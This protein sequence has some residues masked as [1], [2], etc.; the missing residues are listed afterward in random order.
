[1]SLV[2]VQW[3]EYHTYSEFAAGLLAL[4]SSPIVWL[5]AVGYS[6]EG[7]PIWAIKI[8]DYPNIKERHE[9]DVLFVGL[10]HAR[11]W[12]SA[13]VPYYFAW[14][15]VELYDSD[16]VVKRFVDNCEIWIVPVV[17]PDGLEFCRA[18]FE[19]PE[20]PGENSRYWR[21]NRVNNSDG[22]FGVDLNRNYGTSNWGQDVEEGIADGSPNPID[23]TYWGPSAFSEP[24]TVA[25]RDLIL[26]VENDFQAVVSYH[27][28]WQMI[29]YPWGYTPDPP[30][31]AASM[32][33]LSQGMAEAIHA[34]HGEEY[35]VVQGGATYL[36]VGDMGDWVYE[37]KGIPGLTIELRPN[38]PEFDLTYFELPEAEILPTCEENW[39]AALFLMNWV[40]AQ[41]PL[42]LTDWGSMLLTY[43]PVIVGGTAII[44]ACVVLVIVVYRRRASV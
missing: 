37:E 22:T 28:Y 34:V 43:G 25:M 13:E 32:E 12:I 17:N 31:D 9:P 35:T 38:N 33:A 18:Y 41:H 29:A 5:D 10:H 27:S 4:S 21:K 11:E 23:E 16:P 44:I 2:P 40:L 39:A 20:S 26:D 24:E 30:V 15:L 8:S 3:T 42:T 19:S 14:K 6:V 1:M 36:T 7:R